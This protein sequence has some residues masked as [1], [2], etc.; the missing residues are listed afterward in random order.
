MK[1]FLFFGAILCSK[2]GG[3]GLVVDGVYAVFGIKGLRVA[4]CFYCSYKRATVAPPFCFVWAAGRRA[5]IRKQLTSVRGP[6]CGEIAMFVA[7]FQE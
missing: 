1:L 3:G 4:E 6:L 7:Q 2:G 5:G